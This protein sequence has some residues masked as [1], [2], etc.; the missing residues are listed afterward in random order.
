[1]HDILKTRMNIQGEVSS[2]S[3]EGDLT[4]KG[5]RFRK[6]FNIYIGNVLLNVQFQLSYKRDEQK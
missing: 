2:I 3:S 4:L 5:N 1:M 6:A